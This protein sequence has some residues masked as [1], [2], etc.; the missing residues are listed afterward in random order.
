VISFHSLED[1]IVKRFMRKMAGRPEHKM[2]ARSQHER[3]SYGVLERSKAVF[4]TKQE[5][6]N[7]PRS[8]SARLRFISKTSHPEF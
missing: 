8:R 7:N 5:V 6:E 1:R 3:I 4:P 2:D